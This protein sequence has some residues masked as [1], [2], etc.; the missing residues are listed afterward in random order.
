MQNKIRV[1]LVIAEGLALTS[2]M[3]CHK[4]AQVAQGDD[5]AAVTST[6]VDA[7]TFTVAAVAPPDPLVAADPNIPLNE[8]VVGTTPQPV[9]YTADVAPPA[10][11]VEDQPTQPEQDDSWVPG[12]WWWSRPL[13]RYVWVSGAWRHPPPDQM[14]NAGSWTPYNGH[15]TWS[16]GYWGPRGYA[17]E[18]I[19]VAPPPMQV[20][21]MGTAPGDG[22]TWTPGYYGWRE[23]RYAWNAGT[24][25][26]PPSVGVSWV[27]PRY[28]NSGGRYYLQPGRWDYPADHRGTVYRPDI[29]VHPGAHVVLAPVAVAVVSAHAN[30]VNE[31]A[32]AVAFGAT[33]TANG[34]YS[35]VVVRPPVVE[36]RVQG[37]EGV[38]VGVETHPGVVEVR[39]GVVETHPG[40]VEVRPGVVETHPGVV[41][42]HP[43]VVEAHPGVVEPH[44]QAH[45]AVPETHV[46]VHPVAEAH[47]QAHVAAPET[48][49][50]AHTAAPV[51]HTATPTHTPPPP[52]KKR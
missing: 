2:V 10:P 11:V 23:G 34:G 26:R 16:P 27:A 17:R 33:R 50:E 29:N 8:A 51:V 7:D 15:Y 41:E 47:V 32:R 28:V 36:G 31:S 25:V 18:M 21:V 49:V 3:G 37:H 45:V 5:A 20:E 24:W 12:Y 1:V 43:G 40:V 14:W 39:P 52:P 48:H 13:A 44:M 9:D 38:R 4:T 42:T 35:A 6:D 46:E 30:F 22:Y 19:D